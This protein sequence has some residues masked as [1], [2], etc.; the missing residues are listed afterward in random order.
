MANLLKHA[1]TWPID[2]AS[3]ATLVDKALGIKGRR[4]FRNT[5]TWSTRI[6][7]FLGREPTLNGETRQVDYRKPCD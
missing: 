1:G 4:R 5:W 6:L 7:W 3:H 2:V